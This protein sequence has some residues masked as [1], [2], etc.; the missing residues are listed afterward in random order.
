MDTVKLNDAGQVVLPKGSLP[1]GFVDWLN[2]TLLTFDSLGNPTIRNY[3][4]GGVLARSAVAVSGAADTNENTL[5]T[6]TVPANMMG[7]SGVVMVKTWWAYTNSVNNKTL[8]IK[9]NGTAAASLVAT[10]TA[11]AEV[12][13]YIANRGATNSQFVR[14]ESKTAAAIATTVGTDAEDTTA[15]VT[16]LITGEKASGG[17]TLTLEG[18]IVEVIPS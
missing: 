15:S 17:E 4:L 13:A 6:I 11:H 8:R 1:P 16:I 10:T 7:A 9:F 12:S 5:A 18:Y 14:G 2:R 3:S